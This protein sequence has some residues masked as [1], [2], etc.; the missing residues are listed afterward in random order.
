[1]VLTRGSDEVHGGG[2]GGAGV[3][4]RCS[5]CV[6]CV[7]GGAGVVVSRCQGGGRAGAGVGVTS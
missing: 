6:W 7:W 4:V 3:V 5:V 2:E 1:M